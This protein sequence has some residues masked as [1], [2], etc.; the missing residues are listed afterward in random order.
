MWT[1]TT[2]VHLDSLPKPAWTS[3]TS[4][5]SREKFLP[6]PEAWPHRPHGVCTMAAESSPIS[7]F[8]C[9]YGSYLLQAHSA[10]EYERWRRPWSTTPNAPCSSLRQEQVCVHRRDS[11]DAQQCVAVHDLALYDYYLDAGAGYF[12]V[13]KA[14]EP[15]HIQYSY[16]DGSVVVVNSTYESI[17]G[18]MPASMYTILHGRNCSVPRRRSMQ[19]ST[20]RSVSSQSGEPLFRSRQHLL[21]RSGLSD[22]SGAFSAATSTGAWHTDNLRLGKDRLHAY[23][24][25][26]P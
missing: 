1:I 17:A 22:A 8:R 2:A 13:K 9:G 6:D 11:V 25:R 10:A 24:S 19:A 3:H 15:L 23:T 26:K 18:F 14:C 16:D 21:H 20:V 12:A 7:S 4:L 5:A